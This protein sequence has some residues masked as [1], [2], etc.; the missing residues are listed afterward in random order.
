MSALDR[1]RFS[2]IYLEQG[3]PTRDSERFRNRL[4]AFYASEIASTHGSAVVDEFEKE[5]GAIVPGGGA[6]RFFAK[7]IR[8]G[9]LRDVLDAIT[10]I[11]RVLQARFSPDQHTWLNFV[12]RA[13]RETNVGYCIDKNGIVHF[14]VDE[15]FELNRVSAVALLNKPQFGAAKSALDDAYRHLDSDPMD[16]KAAVR[17]MFESLEILAK[18]IE[19]TAKNLNKW[20]VQNTLKPILMRARDYD[21]TEQEVLSRLFDGIAN[22]VDGMHLYRHGQTGHSPVAPS[23]DST[24]LLL[25]TG[26]AYLRLLATFISNRAAAENMQSI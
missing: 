25:S 23:V 13:M 26:T 5:T 7:V 6:P 22:W 8:E 9:A 2:L 10:I 24:I 19:P 18:Q 4:A 21:A 16:T 14:R 15:A 17:S 3:A 11:Y 1:D 20:L 12:A